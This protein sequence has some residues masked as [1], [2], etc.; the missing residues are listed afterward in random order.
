MSVNLVSYCS[1]EIGVS[2]QVVRRIATGAPYMYKKF[3][4]KKRGRDEYRWV[5]QPAREVK[6]LQRAIVKFFHAKLPIH[7]RATAYIDG[8][9]VAKNASL[10][11]NASYLLKMDFSDFFG[12]IQIG[13]IRAFVKAALGGQASDVEL[14]LIAKA[15]T[16][17]MEGGKPLA[18]CIGA[19]SSPFFSNAIMYG[20]DEFIDVQCQRIGICYS[21]YS[22]DLTFTAD[23]REKLLEVESLVRRYLSENTS[24]RLLVNERKR[25]LVGRTSSMRITGVHLSTQ[26]DVTVGR[27]RKRGVRAGVDRFV[28][29]DLN[30]AAVLKLR[31][32]IAFA[33]DVEPGFAALL[34]QWYGD[35]V[36]PLIPKA[37][38]AR[39]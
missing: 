28:S 15:V 8:A 16:W 18:L 2:A 11:R 12:S 24:P 36:S 23:S 20:F 31:G 10:H 26:G 13:D 7:A 19:P 38:R 1:S 25:V 27:I 21:R 22:D 9:S 4:L 33:L 29:G 34:Y 3:R 14:D 35:A 6:A 30:A 5:A 39:P 37:K 32:E 17:H